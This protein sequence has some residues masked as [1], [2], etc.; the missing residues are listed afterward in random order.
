MEEEMTIPEEQVREFDERILKA[1]SHEPIPAHE[2]ADRIGLAWANSGELQ[3]ALASLLEEGK[4]GLI[5]GRGWFKFGDRRT[6]GL[7]PYDRGERLEPK[8]WVRP[9]PLIRREDED[10]GK[11]DFDDDGDYTVATLWI[12]RREDGSYVLKGYNNEPLEV[13]ID[14]QS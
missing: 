7:T 12:E 5:Y 2:L 3:V 9:V 11:V 6:A 10:Y 4:V 13:E 8:P 1:L 14:D